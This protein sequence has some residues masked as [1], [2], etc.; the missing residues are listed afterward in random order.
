MTPDERPSVRNAP[1]TPRGWLIHTAVGL[2]VVGLGASMLLSSGLSEAI[3]AAALSI[4][5]DASPAIEHLS[6]A[7]GHLLQIKLA[8][9]LALEDQQRDPEVDPRPFQVALANLHREMRTYETYPFYPY[10]QEHDREAQKHLLELDGRVS[11]FLDL[12]RS[13][14]LVGAQS[15]ERKQLTEAAFRLD[16]RIQ[17][18]V[19][20]NAEQQ[21]RMALEIPRLRARGARIGYLVGGATS[22]LALLMMGLV[23]RAERRYARLLA[24]QRD[25]TESHA[26][27][28]SEFSARLRSV[29]DSSTRIAQA[30]TA[31]NERDR[32]LQ[33]IV[34]ESQSLLGAQY[35]ALGIGLDPG[36]PFDPWVHSG[37]PAE[38]VNAL[39]TPPRP[40]GVLGAVV[41]GGVAFRLG[42][43]TEHPEF[44]GLPE[45]HPSIGP[46][47]GVPILHQGS[48]LGN[49]FIA[50]KEGE[51]AFSEADLEI[52]RLVA[53]YAGVALTNARL[54]DEAISATRARDDLLATVSHDLKNPLSS[55]RVSTQMLCRRSADREVREVASRIDRATA[56][57]GRLVADL[58]DAAKIESGGLKAERRPEPVS[59]LF[60]SA[61]E[62]SRPLADEKSI[63]ILVELPPSLV[64]LCDP[65]LILRV[66]SNL[67]GNAIKFCTAGG[68]IDLS[69]REAGGNVL[70]S[71]KDSGPGIAPDQLSHVFDRYWQ[72][73]G[74]R[75]GTGLGLYI[76]KGIVEAHGGNVSIESVPGQGTTVLFTLPAAQGDQVSSARTLQ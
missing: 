43:L 54:Y 28:A 71:V 37:V 49:L 8:A 15:F 57:M 66:L 59:A 58:L 2:T 7:R 40:L 11:E 32:L 72:E 21:H 75:R 56:R 46:F 62:G 64:V 33:L 30:I 16:Q 48:N 14:D 29:L 42:A 39:R 63:R 52:A 65:H 23:I 35:S 36:R 45:G 73:K 53:A 47:L 18:L 34:D 1:R 20:F 22:F 13:R 67:L 44:Q 9:A 10:E 69:A 3:D 76:V 5:T 24:L 41:R 70:F 60:D 38:T 27:R 26:R 6:A 19:A 31:G 4:A 17:E 68:S 55:V 50:R 12:L 51:R 74:D 25:E 61:L